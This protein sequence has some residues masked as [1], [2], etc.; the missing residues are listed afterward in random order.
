MDGWKEMSV[1]LGDGV[2]GCTCVCEKVC[3]CE[4]MCMCVRV[5]LCT[6]MFAQ[7]SKTLPGTDQAPDYA[8]G[9]GQEGDGSPAA[10]ISAQDPTAPR[11]ST[12][13]PQTELTACSPILLLSL[14]LSLNIAVHC[15]P[16]APS[17]HPCLGRHHMTPAHFP[18][19]SCTVPHT[20]IRRTAGA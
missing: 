10:L 8:T 14:C 5:R 19:G 7:S 2:E 12:L 17:G 13:T 9:S 18:K 11:P 4:K 3:V 15:Q 20:S 1:K 16:S 6:W